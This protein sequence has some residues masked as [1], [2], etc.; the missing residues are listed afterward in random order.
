VTHSAITRLTLTH[1]R[2]YESLRLTVGARLVAL[3][4]PNGAGKTNLIEAI[5]LLN[6]GRGLRGD[7]LAQFACRSGTGAWA[8]AADALGPNGDVTI[9]TSGF[10]MAENGEE[11]QVRNAMVNGKLASS[12]G[13]LGD[14]LKMFW[15]TPAMDRL[16]AGPPGDRRRFFDR[17]AGLFDPDHGARLNRFEK[18]MRERN[19]LLDD[20]RL[21]PAW[22]AS[23]EFQMAEIAVAIAAGRRMAL[24]TVGS[25]FATPV[26]GG[27]FPWG[28]ITINGLLETQLATDAAVQ[29]EARYRQQLQEGRDADRAAGRCLVGPHRTDIQVTHGPKGMA[30]ETCSTGEQKALL[31][32]LVLAQAAA[33]AAVTGSVPLLLLDEVT[34][35]LDQARRLAL[36]S[37]LN[38]LG[39]QVWMTGTDTLLFDG[40]GP[41]A[42]VYKVDSGRIIES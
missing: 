24:Q 27:V 6:P 30:A 14:Y 1:F 10:A 29:V 40:A 2:N 28:E 19:V 33:A 35:H 17:M 34:A 23:L 3:T 20:A 39:G 21:E 5:S 12:A 4:G 22:L 7:H 9:G 11:Q 32:G 36:F 38:Q 18:L 42:V 16:F 25:Y 41:Q 26:D 37:R 31:L 15:V 13:A 8:V